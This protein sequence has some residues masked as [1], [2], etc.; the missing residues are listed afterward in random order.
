MIAEPACNPWRAF[1]TCKSDRQWF[2]LNALR[3]ARFAQRSR[4]NLGDLVM[5]TRKT[6]VKSPARASS[7]DKRR[8]GSAMAVGTTVSGPSHPTAS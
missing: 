5:P 7:K 8:A 4:I 1:Y 6:R 2:P 3:E